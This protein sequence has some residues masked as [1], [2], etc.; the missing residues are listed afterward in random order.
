MAVTP[1]SSSSL[2]SLIESQRPRM[3]G[4]E[5]ARQGQ[6]ADFQ[7]VL[8]ESTD[9]GRP[10]SGATRRLAME[11]ASPVPEWTQ[12]GT[13]PKMDSGME[14]AVEEVAMAS[15]LPEET[16]E[17]RS[18]AAVRAAL[19]AAGLPASKVSL[20]YREYLVWYPGASWMNHEIRASLSDGRSVDFCAKLAERSPQVTAAEIDEYLLQPPRIA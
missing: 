15:S 4:S 5:R 13:D 3:M 11:D 10:T 9:D 6:F 19:E 17:Q 1:T 14:Q 2:G 7:Q 18:I 12:T 8:G 20:C 16:L